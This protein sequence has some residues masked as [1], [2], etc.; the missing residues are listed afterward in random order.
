MLSNFDVCYKEN[1]QNFS[2]FIKLLPMSES[3]QLKIFQ[4]NIYFLQTVKFKEKIQD[5]MLIQNETKI[6]PKSCMKNAALVLKNNENKTENENH[7]LWSNVMNNSITALKQKAIKF[8]PV[9][10]NFIVFVQNLNF[11]L[12]PQHSV[13]AESCGEESKKPEMN[14]ELYG[15]LGVSSDHSSNSQLSVSGKYDETPS[16]ACN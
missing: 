5:R 11:T 15:K 12:E 14:F 8:N 13:N 16:F 9:L 3:L 10:K 6:T 2:Q 1:K 4:G 7:R